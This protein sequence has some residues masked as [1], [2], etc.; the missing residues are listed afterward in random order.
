[1]QNKRAT[2]FTAFL[3]DKFASEWKLLSETESFLSYTPEATRYEQE[4]KHWRKQL[5]NRKTDDTALVSLRSEIVALRKELRL[6]GYDLSVG[7]QQLEVKGFRNDDSLAEGFRRVVICFCKSETYFQT[8]SANHIEIAE[9]LH[10]SLKRRNLL[11]YPETLFLWFLRMHNKLILSGSATE[12]KK[13][14]E[15]L[16]ERAEANPMKIL[17]ALRSLS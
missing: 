2:S 16:Q 8:G 7:L 4:F 9:N 10:D 11:V 6:Q 12:T 5:Q 17:S 13:D 1:M 3:Q 15:R 14:F